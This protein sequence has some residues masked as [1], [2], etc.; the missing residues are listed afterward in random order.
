MFF[1]PNYVCLCF[2]FITYFFV[3]S[4]IYLSSLIVY[5]FNYE[6]VWLFLF[7]DKKF[8]ETE[9]RHQYELEAD[10]NKLVYTFKNAGHTHKKY[11]EAGD[12]IIRLSLNNGLIKYNPL[13]KSMVIPISYKKLGKF[14]NELFDSFPLPP[15]CE[16]FVFD[17]ADVGVEGIWDPFV[18]TTDGLLSGCAPPLNM[19]ISFCGFVNKYSVFSENFLWTLHRKTSSLH[20]YYQS[21]HQPKQ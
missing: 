7:V 11:K 21:T 13:K 20:L 15:F 9:V 2:D 4:S 1:S 8:E 14:Q 10:F 3:Y 17:A 6:F 5:F 18:C 12:L 19:G 16:V